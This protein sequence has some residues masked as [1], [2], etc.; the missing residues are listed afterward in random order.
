[1]SIENL[2]ADARSAITIVSFLT[3]IGIVCWTYVVHRGKDFDAA[4]NLPFADD[5]ATAES[6]EGGRHV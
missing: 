6:V 5:P 2:F 1:M 3:F 4:A